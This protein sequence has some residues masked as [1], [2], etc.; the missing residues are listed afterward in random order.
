MFKT[1]ARP[2]THGRAKGWIN[3]WGAAGLLAFI[4][5]AWTI[6]DIPSNAVWL[7]SACMGLYTGKRVFGKD[8]PKSGT[9]E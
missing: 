7:W 9:P 8:E 1:A 2:I 6:Q 4:H 5:A 3:A